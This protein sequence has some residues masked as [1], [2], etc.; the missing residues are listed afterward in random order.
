MLPSTTFNSF[1][2]WIDIV[3][4]KNGVRTL[5]NV[6][7]VDTMWADLFHW[8][9]FTSLILH[10]SKINHLRYSSSQGKEL[11]QLTPYWSIPPFSNWSI[12][13]F[14]QTCSCVFTRLCQCHLELERVEGLHLSTLVTFLCQKV[15]I[16]LHKI[17]TPSILSWA[18]AVGLITS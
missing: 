12:W 2:Q 14:T 11:S 8:N 7:I 3:L 1:H 18:I 6:I 13:L 4:T 5:A 9:G 16:T 15:S 17:Q 10:N